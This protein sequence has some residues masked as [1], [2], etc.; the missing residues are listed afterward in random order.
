MS[1]RWGVVLPFGRLKYIDMALLAARFADLARA[2]E[3]SFKER[4]A[5]WS[6]VVE[7]FDAQLQLASDKLPVRTLRAAKLRIFRSFK[8][9]GQ[10]KRSPLSPLEMLARA[11]DVVERVRHQ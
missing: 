9:L 6:R 11:R 5:S 10:Y 3:L 4:R 2:K 7:R 1:K 8:L